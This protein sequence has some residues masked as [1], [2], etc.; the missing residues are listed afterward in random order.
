MPSPYMIY[1]S[2]WLLGM[3]RYMTIPF[4][5]SILAILFEERIL[6]TASYAINIVPEDQGLAAPYITALDFRISNPRTAMTALAMTL[7]IAIIPLYVYNI[8]II[9]SF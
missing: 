6:A 4:D 5:S 7:I 8:Y 3:A 2:T 9:Y 1:L